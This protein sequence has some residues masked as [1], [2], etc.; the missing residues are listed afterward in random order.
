MLTEYQV[1]KMFE[2][3]KSVKMWPNKQGPVELKNNIC[4]VLS[5]SIIRELTKD[6]L[7]P[8]EEH[9]LLF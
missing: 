9:F 8:I 4:K 5:L 6:I 2:R 7:Q 3:G 1:E